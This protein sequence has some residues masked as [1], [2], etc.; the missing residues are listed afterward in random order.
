MMLLTNMKPENDDFTKMVNKVYIRRWKVEEY[1]RFKKQEFGFE[2]ELLVRSL[3][4]I[5]MLN[6][7]LTVVIGFIAMFSDNQKQ[8]QYKIVFKA[9]ES[10]RKN[11]DIT[12]VFYAVARGLKTIFSFNLRGFKNKKAKIEVKIEGQISFL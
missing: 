7:L 4:S 6:V 1:F 3:N 9:S 2:K 8:V 11:E 10:L 5:R 12:L